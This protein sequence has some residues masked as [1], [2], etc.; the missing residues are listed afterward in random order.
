MN[1]DKFPK[2]NIRFF[3]RLTIVYT[4][5]SSIFFLVLVVTKISN[6]E[7]LVPKAFKIILLYLLIVFF[8]YSVVYFVTILFSKNEFYRLK[9]LI[10]LCV[11]D[12][13]L[14]LVWL[15]DPFS[16]LSFFLGWL[17]WERHKTYNVW[18]PFS[19]N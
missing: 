15:W 2:A 13:L 6:N 9:L 8:F 4:L 7:S 17:F 11:N 10:S 12:L 5:V 18:S 16:L 19:P 14:L 3:S 1:K